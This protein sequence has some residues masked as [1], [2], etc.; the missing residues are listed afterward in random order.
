M[1]FSF[2]GLIVSVERGVFIPPAGFIAEQHSGLDPLV[3]AEDNLINN[4][5]EFGGRNIPRNPQGYV[6]VRY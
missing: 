5:V 4:L 3:E 6:R 2:D 1:K